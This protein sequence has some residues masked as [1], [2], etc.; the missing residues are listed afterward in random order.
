[1]SKA[2]NRIERSDISALPIEIISYIFR[3]LPISDIKCAALVC[4]AWSR[5][6]EDPILICQKCLFMDLVFT[7]NIRH[8]ASIWGAVACLD[9][10]YIISTK[11]TADSPILTCNEDHCEH[12]RF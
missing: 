1:M 4:F 6:A 9:S 7:T 8:L 2:V 12:C 3:F 10:S 5:A 11:I